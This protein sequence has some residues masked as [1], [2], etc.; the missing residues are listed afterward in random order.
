M[1]AIRAHRLPIQVTPLLTP[2]VIARFDAR[3]NRSGG[4]DACWPWMGR[5]ERAGYGNFDVASNGARALSTKA[6]R[7][8]L[9]IAGREPRPEEYGCHH[10]DNPPC[11]N[12]AH[13]FVG[14]NRDNQADARAKG[15]VGELT[16][17]ERWARGE[18]NGF[19]RLTEDQVRAIRAAYVP[20]RVSYPVLARRF[21]VAVSTIR[22]VI[23]RETWAHVEDAA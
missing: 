8:A 21:G 11:C 14:T 17:P 3:V 4:P 10:C 9:A 15:R 7:V 13:L 6:H 12:P 2:T 22:L 5:R 1:T 20:Y 19:A 16:H 23:H 18:H